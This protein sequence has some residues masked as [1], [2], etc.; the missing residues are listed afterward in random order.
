MAEDGTIKEMRSVERKKTVYYFDVFDWKSD[1]LIGH[2]VDITTEGMMLISD[3][4]IETGTVFQLKMVLP[5]EM[6]GIKQ[7]TF[8]AK[9]AW[10]AKDINPDYFDTGFKFTAISDED[11]ER[12]EHILEAY[13]FK[14]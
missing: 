2:A 3:G 6:D 12:I 11:I 5:F 7:I 13:T 4:K 8:D 1:K 14:D 10:C 9:S